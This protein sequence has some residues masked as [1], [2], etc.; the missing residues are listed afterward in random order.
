MSI[1]D[2]PELVAELQT[3]RLVE[4]GPGTV[5]LQNPPGTHDDLAVAVGMCLVHLYNHPGGGQGRF[6]GLEAARVLLPDVLDENSRRVA[7]RDG[8]NPWRNSSPWV[9]RSATSKLASW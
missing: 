1:P 7:T 5:K 2:D 3:A 6:S 9:I 8:F 4:T